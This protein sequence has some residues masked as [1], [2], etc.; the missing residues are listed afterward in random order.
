[1]AKIITTLRDDALAVFAGQTITGET[2]ESHTSL[3]YL[4]ERGRKQTFGSWMTMTKA[5]EAAG[6]TVDY[7]GAEPAY[8]FPAA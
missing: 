8:T 1:M 3:R 2:L 7:S 5:L 6:M 4:A